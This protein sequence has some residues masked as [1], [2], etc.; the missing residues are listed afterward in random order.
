M[1]EFYVGGVGWGEVGNFVWNM[2]LSA[3]APHLCLNL[4]LRDR[5]KHRAFRE[6]EIETGRGQV[7]NLGQVEGKHSGE[8]QQTGM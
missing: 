2:E 3:L 7:D 6:H 5:R 1:C 8:G 4:G